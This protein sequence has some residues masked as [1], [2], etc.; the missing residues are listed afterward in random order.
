[1]LNWEYYARDVDIDLSG[2]PKS[3]FRKYTE[4]NSCLIDLFRIDCS[5]SMR[6]SLVGIRIKVKRKGANGHDLTKRPYRFGVWCHDRD[7]NYY[8]L[9]AKVKILAPA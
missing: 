7:E 6:L 4:V 5:L 2:R 8:A 1:M 9:H 3:N